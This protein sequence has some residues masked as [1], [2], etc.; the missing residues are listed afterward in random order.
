MIL[1]YLEEPE[2][3]NYYRAVMYTV[4]F[5][6]NLLI[7]YGV[8]G[9]GVGYDRIIGNLYDPTLTV[10][11]FNVLYL[12]ITIGQIIHEIVGKKNEKNINRDTG[13]L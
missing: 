9:R 3:N 2:K 11:I 4:I 8:S 5:N 10:A 7:F 6:V 1:L 13:L 12:T